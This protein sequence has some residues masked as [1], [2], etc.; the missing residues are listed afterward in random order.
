MEYSGAGGYTVICTKCRDAGLRSTVRVLGT[1]QTDMPRDVYF[2]ED[3]TEHSHNPNLVT[4]QF[5]CSNGHRFQEV[6]S[7]QCHCG[8][9]ACEAVVTFVGEGSEG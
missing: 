2:D 9:K 7:W 3:G 4:T 1:K 5:R 6:S 8:Y